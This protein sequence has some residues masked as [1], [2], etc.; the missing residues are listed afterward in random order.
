MLVSVTRGKE[1]DARGTIRFIGQTLF[2]TGIWIGVELVEDVGKNNG[3]VQGQFYFHCPPNR[4]LFVREENVEP[5]PDEAKGSL[6]T[7][8][9][10]TEI[11]ATLQSASLNNSPARTVTHPS[12]SDV[13]LERRA[14]TTSML[15][16]KLSQLMNLLNQQLEIVKELEEDIASPAR[17]SKADTEAL[18][19]EIL[20]LTEQE[21]ELVDSFKRRLKSGL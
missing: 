15:K 13:D 10:A 16:L 19:S 14:E 17:S 20:E 12:W 4:G 2:A 18:Y 3:T 8:D 6:M 5:L 9:I 1:A 11:S 21:A 7:R